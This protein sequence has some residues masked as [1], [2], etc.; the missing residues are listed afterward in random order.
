MAEWLNT[1]FAGLDGGA[2]HF[3]HN[4]ANNCG[5]FLTPLMKIITS[6][7]DGG[8]AFITLGII[9][10]FFKNTRKAGVAVLLAIALGSVFTNLTL[11][12]IVARPRPYVASEEYK[13]FWLEVNGVLESEKSFPSGHTTTAAAAMAALF[14]C[15]NK[16]WSWV[17]FF[18]AALI[19]FTRIYVVVHYLTDVV[20]GFLVG[21]IAGFLGALIG[22]AVYSLL[23]KHSQNKVINCILNFDIIGVFKK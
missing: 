18:V 10:L 23:E 16:K 13:Q 4:L 19:G 8:W 14:F 17:L 11:K 20:A 7:G 5:G 1:T 2:F 21:T 9:L 3:V 22:K 6:L 12:K 15:F